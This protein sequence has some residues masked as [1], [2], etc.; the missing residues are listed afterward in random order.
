MPVTGYWI[1]TF[2][3][4]SPALYV[5]PVFTPEKVIKTWYRD[6]SSVFV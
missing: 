3:L 1:K 2:H 4:A 5:D 6:Y